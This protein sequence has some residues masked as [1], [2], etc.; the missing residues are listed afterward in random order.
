MRTHSWARGG[1]A[2]SLLWLAVGSPAPAEPLYASDGAAGSLPTNLYLLDAS[3]GAVQATVGPVRL[4]A[5]NLRLG[6]LTFDPQTGVL[7]ATTAG[8]GTANPRSLV[9]LDPSTG[10]ATLIGSLGLPGGGTLSDLAV[11][12]DGI[13]Y[14]ISGQSAGTGLFTVNP[15]TGQATR[16]TPF[17]VGLSGG[18]LAFGPGGALYAAGESSGT[19]FT[20]NAT[21]GMFT[22]GPLLTGSPIDDGM[23]TALAFDDQGNLFG[24]IF[25]G[26]PFGGPSAL[27][28]VDPT[29][30]VITTIAS[31]PPVIPNGL[32]AIAFQSAGPP[33]SSGIPEPASLALLG[34]GALGLLACCRRVRAWTDRHTLVTL[35]PDS[36]APPVPSTPD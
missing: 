27:V 4:G 15:T 17:A 19:L 21:T 16:V 34:I 35:L 1:L 14:G 5:T 22:P 11:G 7:Y 29:T 30:G 31:G 10:A 25:R 24:T 9:T 32:N 3:T 6:G 8:R 23:F 2:A 33:P 28:R 20:V 18:A 12:P 26:S 36:L 13:L